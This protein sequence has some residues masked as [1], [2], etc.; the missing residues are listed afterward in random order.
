MN[1][2]SWQFLFAIGIVGTL[3]VRRGGT[4]PVKGW[5]VALAG[6]YA[7]FALV[8]VRTPLWGTV[9]WFGLPPV[10]GGFDKT[11]LSLSRLLHVL[12]V[13]YLVSCLCSVSSALRWS[14]DNP[15]VV[16]GRRSLPVF[17]AGTLLAM[18]TQVLRLIHGGSPI[19]DASLLAAGAMAQ[20]ALAYY[21]DWQARLGKEPA[22]GRPVPARAEPAYVRI[23]T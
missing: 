8:W 1:P 4:I 2:L 5:A 13:G 16:L 3:H 19:Y 15:L 14:L 23:K 12:A 10:L 22:P 11:F 7:V 20:F 9:T 17:V 18:A 21:L 6:A